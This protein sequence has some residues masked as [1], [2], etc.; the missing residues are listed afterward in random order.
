MLKNADAVLGR[1]LTRAA[2]QANHVLYAAILGISEWGTLPELGDSLDWDEPSDDWEFMEPIHSTRSLIGLVAPDGS[3]PDYG[4]LPLLPGEL[5]PAGVLDGVEPDQEDTRVTG[6]AGVELSRSYRRAALVLWPRERTVGT[7]AR[8]DIEGALAWF[9][10]D[11]ARSQRDTRSPSRLCGL[12][13]QLI[14]A[15]PE[16]DPA[17]FFCR[18]HSDWSQPAYREALRLLRRL[19]DEATIRR[20]LCEVA[21]QHYSGAEND[22]LLRT[23]AEVAPA[24]LHAWLPQFTAVNFPHATGD[25]LGLLRRLHRQEDSAPDPIRRSALVEAVRSVCGLLPAVVEGAA[26]TQLAPARFR[27]T[28]RWDSGRPLTARAI[29]SLFALIWHCAQPAAAAEAAALLVQHPAAAPPDRALP[30]ALAEL[31]KLDGMAGDATGSAGFATLWRHAAAFLL[32][33]SPAPPEEP[34]DW[35]IESSVG[36]DC[37]NCRRLQA[38]CADPVATTLRF[39]VRQDIRLHVESVITFGRLD[40]DGRTEHEGRPY[41]L[42]CTKTRGSYERRCAQYAQDVA[43]MRLLVAAVPGSDVAVADDLKQLHAALARA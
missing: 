29:R 11:L 5:L 27:P 13:A 38:F 2:Q 17:R 23:A 16:P 8:G 12:A 35:L 28:S 10:D 6:N 3:R 1:V 9:G 30:L 26:T 14:E 19:R 40:I 37:P 7:L 41:T 33:R 24:V 36:C 15:W 21:T 18:H 31:A 39:S 4:E 20:F 34:R 42:I 22:E 43:H 32:A 25:V